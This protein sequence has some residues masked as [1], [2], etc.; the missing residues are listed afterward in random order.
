M[1]MELSAEEVILIRRYLL[2]GIAE[3]D[4]DLI[5][6]RLPTDPQ[7]F[8]QLVRGEE[9]LTDRYVRR[10]LSRHE[11]EKDLAVNKDFTGNCDDVRQLCD[12]LQLSI[13]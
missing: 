7:Y 10:D 8:N 1:K 3:P 12:D 2:S 6:A 9:E 4:R 11:S 5:E 13:N